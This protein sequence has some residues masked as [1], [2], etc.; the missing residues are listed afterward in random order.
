MRIRSIRPEFWSSEDVAA[1]DWDTRLV[2]IGLW[3]YV[4]DNGVGRD[5]ER[6]IVADLF[7]LDDDLSE[8]SR[9]VHGA[10]K[11]LS[12]G[13][14]ITRYTVKGKPYLHV[15]TF[16]D[17][18]VINR[19][20]KGRYPLP[21]CEDAEPVSTLTEDSVSPQQTPDDGEG[22]KGR[23]GKEEELLSGKPDDG[24][25]LFADFY[26]AYPRKEARRAAEK[27]WRAA[28]K[29]ADPAEIM[30]GLERFRFSDDRRFIPLPASWLNA[31]RWADS[32]SDN[33]TP[34]RGAESLTREQIDDILG[35]DSETL[36]P[37]PDLDPEADFPRYDA[38]L[39]HARADRRAERQRQA[40][41]ELERRVTS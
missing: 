34:I 29:R 36:I 4:D 28:V 12:D 17:H 38:W 24:P 32:P 41:A 15:T 20:S 30:A 19:P 27:A 39:T 1:L 26:S 18:Q 11:L 9:K 25:D 13:G 8:S 22:E 33:V 3:S 5:V 21:T 35:P 10:L 2:F 31:D 23:R 14:L 37:P 16:A 40:L 6:L 7:P